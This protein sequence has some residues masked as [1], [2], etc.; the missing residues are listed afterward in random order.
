MPKENKVYE[1]HFFLSFDIE[2]KIRDGLAYSM[3][4]SASCLTNK[5]LPFFI[6]LKTGGYLPSLLF[7]Q[8]ERYSNYSLYYSLLR[9][10]KPFSQA[11]D[12]KKLMEN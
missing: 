8:K 3:A 7:L 11:Q 12:I 1:N 10:N 6:V 4:W 2:K 9:L 5:N